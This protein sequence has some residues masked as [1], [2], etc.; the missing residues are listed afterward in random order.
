MN[1]LIFP[2][3]TAWTF[4]SFLSGRGRN[5]WQDSLQ[6]KIKLHAGSVKPD[7]FEPPRALFHKSIFMVRICTDIGRI[8]ES[9]GLEQKVGREY[10]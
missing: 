10:F 3:L 8:S 2:L 1:P 4:I 5:L 9:K 6:R 7:S